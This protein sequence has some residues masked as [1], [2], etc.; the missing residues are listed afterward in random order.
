MRIELTDCSGAAYEAIK[1]RRRR[2]ADRVRRTGGNRKAID[3]IGFPSDGR[4]LFLIY[5]EIT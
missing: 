1:R 3:V 4:R 2:S 5:S